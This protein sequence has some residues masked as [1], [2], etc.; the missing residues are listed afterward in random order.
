MTNK[1]T[2]KFLDS[3]PNH[4]FDKGT[5]KIKKHMKGLEELDK[6]LAT[7]IVESAKHTI[8]MAAMVLLDVGAEIKWP[9]APKSTKKVEKKII[10]G[11]LQQRAARLKRKI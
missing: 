9:T 2:K 1:E 3:I 11:R 8:K 7:S 5:E 4:V 10:T 6:E